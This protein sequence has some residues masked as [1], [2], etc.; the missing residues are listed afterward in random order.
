MKLLIPI[1]IC[2]FAGVLASLA[3]RQASAQATIPMP[4]ALTPGN[5]G[6]VVA[7]GPSVPELVAHMFQAGRWA[8]LDLARAVPAFYEC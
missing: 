7:Q 2:V 8:K 5:A 4:V 3:G 1:A 6:Y